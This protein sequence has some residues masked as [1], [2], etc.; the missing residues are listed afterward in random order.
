[1]K[2]GGQVFLMELDLVS[3]EGKAQAPLI[4]W[5]TGRD[6]SGV[7]NLGKRQGQN[8]KMAGDAEEG[9]PLPQHCSH[10]HHLRKCK[11]SQVTTMLPFSEIFFFSPI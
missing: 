1:M 7:R 3:R 2:L 9:F 11:V 6:W 5:V 10:Q 4:W 8:W